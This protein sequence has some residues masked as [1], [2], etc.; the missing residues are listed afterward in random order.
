MIGAA[1]RLP[2]KKDDLPIIVVNW[3]QKIMVH[4]VM[5]IATCAKFM[6]EERIEETKVTVI[7]PQRYRD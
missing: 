6:I 1:T 7:Q 3:E 2:F 5:T 4:Y